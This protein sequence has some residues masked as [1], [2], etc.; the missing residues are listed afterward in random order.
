MATVR[1]PTRLIPGAYTMTVELDGLYYQLS[2][3]FNSRENHWY[4]GVAR[5][6]VSVLFGVKVVHSDDLF[7]Q[8]A[9]MQVDERLPPG[10]FQVLDVTGV[11]RDP[12][13]D[14]FGDDVVM[15]YVEA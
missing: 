13:I 5:N 4:I 8:F 14:N 15:L 6:N 1:I 9:H 10:T 3:H 7:S 12:V 2:F 11:D